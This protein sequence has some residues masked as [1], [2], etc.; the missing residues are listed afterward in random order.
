[1]TLLVTNKA[2]VDAAFDAACPRP[3][4]D[5]M[6]ET[7]PDATEDANGRFHAPHDGYLCPI[8]DR[9]FRAGEFLPQEGD[10]DPFASTMY[11]SGP[12][13]PQARDLDGNLH[14]WEGSKAQRQAVWPLLIAQTRA[15]EASVSKHVGTIG[16]MENL[17]DL[18]LQFVKGFEGFYGTVWIHILKD[19]SGN[20]VV[21]KGSKRLTNGSKLY[22][23]DLNKGDVANIRCKI[24]EHGEREGVK[25]TVVQRP[26][27]LT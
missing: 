9:E 1:M 20:V 23:K 11:G 16:N 25:Q 8:T 3:I 5:I 7:Y 27:I 17:N 26:K 19:Q 6:L 15:H 13:F 4:R 21:Y 10:E 24:K 12:N 14:R 2:L 22:P 18:V